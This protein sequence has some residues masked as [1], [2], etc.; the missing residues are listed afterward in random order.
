MAG[1]LPEGYGMLSPAPV[2]IRSGEDAEDSA[3]AE[4]HWEEQVANRLAI[5]SCRW[6][7][8]IVYLLATKN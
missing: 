2:A 3:T 7:R 5:I 6:C 8:R 4:S 1:A